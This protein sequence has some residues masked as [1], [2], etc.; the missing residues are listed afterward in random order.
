[1]EIK[2]TFRKLSSWTQKEDTKVAETKS[3]MRQHR[4]KTGFFKL[5]KTAKQKHSELK[6]KTLTSFV[7]DAQSH[8]LSPAFY[9]KQM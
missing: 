9:L 7:Y 8:F 3:K 2:L 1:M 4:T 5:Q 6:D